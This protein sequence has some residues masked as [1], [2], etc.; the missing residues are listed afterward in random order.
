M[1]VEKAAEAMGRDT[2]DILEVRVR[3]DRATLDSEDAC[4]L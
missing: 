3:A 2:W 1:Q 4:T